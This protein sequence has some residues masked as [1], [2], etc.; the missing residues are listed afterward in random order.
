MYI[1]A[2]VMRHSKRYSTLLR[3]LYLAKTQKGYRHL[4]KYIVDINRLANE[5]SVFVVRL[6]ILRV[7]QM[8]TTM[9]F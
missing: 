3:R 5:I 1:N 7:S 2:Y 8:P 9:F 4:F 6:Y